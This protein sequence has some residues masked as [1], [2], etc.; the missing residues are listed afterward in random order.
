MR[1]PISIGLVVV[2]LHACMPANRKDTSG[3][4]TNWDTYL[5]DPARTHYS[6]LTQITPENV[7]QLEVAWSYNSG[8]LRGSRST[9][10]T[11]PL[12]VEGT[13][14]GLSPRLVAFALDAATSEELWRYSDGG[15]DAPQRDMMW[16]QACPQKIL[17]LC[18]KLSLGG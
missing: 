18:M 6:T 2:A 5:G 17:M 16:W 12:I 1:Y 3:L 7:N 8:G 10:F 13:L 9:M 15:D 14:Y 4:N 11:S